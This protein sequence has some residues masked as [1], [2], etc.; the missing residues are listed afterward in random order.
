M[1]QLILF[2]TLILLAF[3]A[4]AQNKYN[5]QT[6]TTSPASG[7]YEIITSSIALRETYLLDK[8]TGDTWQLVSG[9]SGFVW[10]QIPRQEH[11]HD[12]VP[13]NYHDYVYQ[14]TLSGIAV[15]GSYLINTITGATWI[16]Y[17]DNDTGRVFWGTI[18][19]PESFPVLG[20]G[21]GG[22]AVP[23]RWAVS[24]PS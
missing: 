22:K 7:R 23:R 4:T 13:E 5:N 16:L 20:I 11:P 12:I 14:I 21:G 3:S 2:L 8:E 24:L 18:A 17:E 15:K 1:K 6:A 19:N 9:Y 10:E